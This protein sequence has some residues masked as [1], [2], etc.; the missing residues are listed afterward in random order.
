MVADT[1]KNYVLY[2]KL[3][4][5]LEAG[6]QAIEAC[7]SQPLPTK[8]QTIRVNNLDVVVQHYRSKDPSEKKYEGH[9]KNLDIQF[10]VSGKEMIYR[11]NA[12][13][14]DP[15]TEYSPERDH[16]SFSDGVGPSA[17]RLGSGD[18]AI[19]YPGDA[20]KTGCV[21]D[22]P[23]DVVKLIVKIPLEESG[24]SSV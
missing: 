9:R 3:N 17:L 10:I 8:N 4:P 11:E 1:L 23:C 16:L 21:W 13:K 7:L 15:C 6:F 24:K 5:L 19:F 2:A 22:E 18:F 20:H 12:E 14:L